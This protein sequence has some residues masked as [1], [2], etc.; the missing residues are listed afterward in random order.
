MMEWKMCKI[1]K[2]KTL[3]TFRTYHVSSR[4][5]GE[6]ERVFRD[7]IPGQRELDVRLVMCCVCGFFFYRDGFDL[8]EL[9][10]LYETEHRIDRVSQSS[11]K[12]GRKWE[13]ESMK[14]FFGRWPEVYS[15]ETAIDVG[16]GDFSTLDALL[17]LFPKTR[18]EAIDPSYGA[19]EYHGI[20]VHD[21]MLENFSVSR[22][23][24]LVLAIHILE[25][26][27]DLHHFMEKVSSLAE[28]YLY[29]EVP[30]QVGLGLLRN[31][32][33]NV[34]HINYYTPESLTDLLTRFGFQILH[35]EFDTDGYRHIGMPGMIRVAAK[36]GTKTR[37]NQNGIICALLRFFDPRPL[38]KAFM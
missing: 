3:F 7:V 12:K 11:I 21:S 33:A 10:R 26:V 9:S 18:F 25:H 5:E 15:V 20:S 38:F 37:R 8:S 19:S 22:K 35:L 36:K 6:W 1:C 16:A 24:D 30:Y 13:I 28:K 17:P 34:Q 32:S 29:I 4:S 2:S 31:A 27:G 23:Y 14:K